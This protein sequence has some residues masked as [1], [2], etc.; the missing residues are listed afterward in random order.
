[1]AKSHC[2]HA[3]ITTKTLHL[4][5]RQCITRS[6][7]RNRAPFSL[8]ISRDRRSQNLRP[9]LCYQHVIFDANAAAADVVIDSIP[10]Y[11]VS[12]LS[13]SFRIV[14][15]GR[16]EIQARLNSCDVADSKRQV[17]T[18]ISQCRGFILLAPWLP[19]A[20][21]ADAKPDEVA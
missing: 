13:A 12:I 8:P 1:M 15:N 16:D 18:Q 11:A 19:A 20:R 2:C 6:R 14:E 10:V 4:P 17:H 7:G 9:V 21:I 3:L 5:V